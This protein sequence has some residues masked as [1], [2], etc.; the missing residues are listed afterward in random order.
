[1]RT[2]LAL[3]SF[4]LLASTAR[5]EKDWFASLYTGDGIELRA[6]ERVFALYALFNAMGYDDAPLARQDPI[7]KRKFHPVREQVRSK[8]LAI[9]P[10]L[11]KQVDAFFDAH[12]QPLGRYLAYAASSAPPPF[13]TGAKAKELSD[14]KGLEGL[15]AKAWTGMKL[16]ELM[17]GVQ[18]EYRKGLKGYLTA[19]DEPMAKARKMLRVPEGGPES[20]LVLNL[21]DAHDAV[22]GVL[23]DGEVLL[24][25]GPADK[26]NVEGVVREYARVNVEP[27]VSKKAKGWGGGAT[28]LREAQALGAQERTVP[29]YATALV[30]RALA[31]KATGAPE[32]AYDAA[33]QRG[34]FGLRE[35]AKGFDDARPLAGWLMDAL[36]KAEARRPSPKK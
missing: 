19:V 30:S 25:V 18:A 21:L 24:V 31:L 1:M 6:D 26:P 34:Y 17:G 8:V 27:V 10:E 16:S 28:M 32:A 15:L 23:G 35:L 13:S 36:A 2:A 11:R 9:D 12:P 3:A 14:L 29:E 5:A 33:A 20:T 22:I 4:F 7:P